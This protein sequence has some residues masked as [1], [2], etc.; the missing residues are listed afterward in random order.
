MKSG[1]RS[2]PR[3]FHTNGSLH[4]R[5]IRRAPKGILKNISHFGGISETGKRDDSLFNLEA[6]IARC[7]RSSISPY[8]CVSRESFLSLLPGEEA[9]VDERYAVKVRCCARYLDI[10]RYNI[11]RRL[12]DAASLF[13]PCDIELILAQ[14]GLNH[15]SGTNRIR[16]ARACLL[17]MHA[18]YVRVCVCVCSCLR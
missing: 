5:R 4:A 17:H 6:R 8:R 16:A 2:S 1:T 10:N 13:S 18:M 14:H 3:A 9:R 12:D 11:C 7:L 15:V